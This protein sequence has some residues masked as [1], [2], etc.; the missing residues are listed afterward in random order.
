[1]KVFV[2]NGYPRSGK[3]EFVDRVK[4]IGEAR[5]MKISSTSMI[6]PVK[7]LL[8]EHY[9]WSP[10]Q[11]KEKDR[12][13]LSNMKDLL[14]EYCDYSFGQVKLDI[15][16]SGALSEDAIF[17]DAREPE[18]IKR[19]QEKFHAM[20]IFIRRDNHETA[21]NHADTEVENFTYDIEI[22]N[23]G[24]LEDLEEAAKAFINFY[25]K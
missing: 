4:K 19:L 23:N 10:S 25:I 13:F 24:T 16:C 1:M 2:V 17:I 21:T 11:K 9:I 8:R 18:D 7:Q 3:G 6:D 14:D 15:I 5:K 20:T 22:D 12:N